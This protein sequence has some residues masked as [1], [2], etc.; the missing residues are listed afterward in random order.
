[1]TTEQIADR[2]FIATWS[3][4]HLPNETSHC[5]R[6]ILELFKA[7]LKTSFQKAIFEDF[8]KNKKN[9]IANAVATEMQNLIEVDYNLQSEVVSMLEKGIADSMIEIPHLQ[10]VP[11]ASSSN[12]IPS[13][14]N[15]SSGSSDTRA[16]G[17]LIFLA[18][19]FFTLM[20]NG[21]SIFYGAML[22]GLA[23]MITGR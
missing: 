11:L 20:S 2:A 1:M 14:S 10:I 3:A 17:G 19:I 13:Y 8:E 18:G 22:I 12:Y 16:I 9:S 6:K 15:L 23:K 5:G 7:N 4:L 21:H